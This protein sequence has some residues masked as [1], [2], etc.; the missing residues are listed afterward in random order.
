MSDRTRIW[1]YIVLAEVIVPLVLIALAGGGI[2]AALRLEEQDSFCAACHT[3]PEMKYVQQAHA[4]ASVQTLA[5]YH[6]R[7]QGSRVRCIDCHSSAGAFGRALGSTQGAHDLLAFLSG[8]YRSPAVTTNPL[9]DASCTKCHG[10]ILPAQVVTQVS[11]LKDHFHEY[12]PLWHQIEPNAARCADCHV[13]HREG[14]ASESFVNNGAASEV[15]DKC[16]RALS[17]KTMR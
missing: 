12:L 5:A 14:N 10:D 3:Q 16:H 17:G 2:V 7:V 9:P 15:C 8:N 1:K 11:S 13:A 6:A 4:D